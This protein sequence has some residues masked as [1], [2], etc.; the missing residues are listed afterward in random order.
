M[1]IA[2]DLL[3][4]LLDDDSGTV[5]SSLDLRPVLGGAVLV[6][7]ALT[8]AVRVSD[9]S[10]FWQSAKV[11]AQSGAALPDPILAA[12]LALVAEKERGAQ[13]LVG[14]LG[15][16]LREQ[17]TERLAA[18]GILRREDS[19]VLGLF[20]RTVWPAADVAREA[21]VR[22]ALTSVLVEGNEPDERTAALVALL[23]AIGR[24]HK[25]VPHEGLPAREVKARAK[26]I[27]EGDWAAK[28]V[29]DAI[30]A[31]T[32]AMVAATVAA[33]TAATTSG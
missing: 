10:G 26:R 29:K 25:T 8:G 13:D 14:R 3:L 5:P 12:A 2:E 4:L 28:A 19:K 27:A 15:K 6:Q 18:Q 22:R 33:T 24:A 11:R 20:P 17:L 21:D 9:K 31:A 23:H 30:D 16:G 7:L 1:L 32:A